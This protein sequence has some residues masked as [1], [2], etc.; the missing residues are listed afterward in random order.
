[1]K[2]TSDTY[3]KIAKA[4]GRY[5][6]G[7]KVTCHKC[8]KTFNNNEV[9][10]PVDNNHSTRKHCFSCAE[11]KY[12]F[13]TRCL[14]FFNTNCHC[15][16]HMNEDSAVLYSYNYYPRYR[17]IGSGEPYLGLEF[18]LYNRNKNIDYNTLS[19]T[20]ISKWGDI[21]LCKWDGSIKDR[22]GLEITTHILSLAYI[23]SNLDKFND[24]F[25]MVLKAGY[26]SALEKTCSIHVHYSN[27]NVTN[28]QLENIL[29]YFNKHKPLIRILSR[30]QYPT[31]YWKF[32]YA[33]KN[34]LI[35]FAK[36][37]YTAERNSWLNFNSIDNVE[38]RL[39]AGV[40]SV[41]RLL[42][43]LD[44]VNAIMN[45]GFEVENLGNRRHVFREYV[46][47]NKQRYASLWKYLKDVR[48]SL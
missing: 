2:M 42:Y 15:N 31:G 34:L 7:L 4:N 20:I 44:T 9:I 36:N 41:D 40:T 38:F 32:D 14:K 45:F 47:D 3:T 16:P 13:C 37:F 17:T 1:M 33:D 46:G 35:D 28:K 8:K 21:V 27:T 23:M 48:N 11:Q 24:I 5:I 22:D 30:R 12:K 39:F 29:L 19:N 25:K 6:S 43:T 18:E 10:F 26:I